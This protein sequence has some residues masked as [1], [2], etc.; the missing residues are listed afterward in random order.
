MQYRPLGKTGLNVSPLTIG[1]W[2]LGGPLSFDGKPDGHPD[3]GEDHVLRMIHELDDCGINAIDTAEQYSG[4]ESERRVGEA[5]RGRRDH[6]VISTKFGY[7][8]G[9]GNTR[10]D[11]SSPET[12]LPSLEGSLRRLKTD[13]IDV[14][15]YHC[16]PEIRNLD[17]GREVLEAARQQGKIRFYGISTNHTELVR[18]MT[19]H[20]AVEVVQFA[21]SLLEPAD[22]L[23]RLAAEQQLG[24]QVRGVMAGG[25]LSGKYFHRRPEWRPD[26]NRS[27]R[28]ADI[29]FQKYA[30]FEKVLPEGYTMAQAAL[31][32]VLDRP[33]HHT[34]CMGAKRIED[35]RTALAA[36]QL[37]P[38]TAEA[39]AALEN[40]AA[41]LRDR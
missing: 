29:D 24:T 8:V 13:Y 33:E 14:Y 6:W 41:A 30:A 7:R 22:E 25:R 12:I 39:C 9:P 21:F 28:C 31:R 10:E 26:D 15:L 16:A 38:L 5:L 18:A 1:A 34:V 20:R 40:C 32:W 3:P 17:A 11:N 35:Y 36:L 27:D 23:S 37:P 19:E 2:Q 4:G